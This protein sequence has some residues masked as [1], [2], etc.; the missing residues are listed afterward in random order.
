MKP[1]VL[2]LLFYLIVL[3]IFTKCSQNVENSAGDIQV[4]QIDMDKIVK[5]YDMTNI[6]DT[7]FSIVPLETNDDCLIGTIDKLEIKADRIYIFDN[8]SKS[9]FIFN[10]DGKFINK[11]NAYGRAPGEYFA[12]SAAT[13]TDSTI[14]I[15]DIALRKLLEYRLSGK[16]IKE[17]NKILNKLW[18]WDMFFYNGFLYYVND[19]GIVRAGRYR[20]FTT[21]LSLDKLDTHL[22][23]KEAPIAL[24]I[25]G[26]RYS[27]YSDGF[28]VIYSG[29][30]AIF[31]LKSDGT[32]ER[33]YT[34]DLMGERIKYKSKIVNKVLE[35]N[36]KGKIIGIEKIFETDR[37]LFLEL[38][39][40]HEMYLLC[41]Y[42]KQN[43]VTTLTEGGHLI[44]D[45]LGFLFSYFT[46][47]MGDK[48]II[49]YDAFNFL[50]IYKHVWSVSDFPNKN[51]NN[52]IKRVASQLK[53][54]DNPV[55]II[56]HL[57]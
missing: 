27:I 35:E 12:I 16:F 11:I 49:S 53:E 15:L 18:A 36:P 22:P 23:F 5:S 56:S 13:V 55:L 21:P 51:V 38:S 39:R 44:H 37:Y 14:I 4:I 3:L 26:P 20:L 2:V 47:M 9:I 28:S 30:D 48:I 24:G 8:M 25:K 54:G 31:G 19:W 57:K 41:I 17:D 6:I 40:L 34:V 52:A 46:W 42:D 7:S 10:M 50:E 33:K 43:G 45:S 32:I 29:V 1:R